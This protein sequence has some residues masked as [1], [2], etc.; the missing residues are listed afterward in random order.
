VL[1]STPLAVEI[2]PAPLFKSPRHCALAVRFIR[3]RLRTIL[4]VSRVC[5]VA[6]IS[7]AAIALFAIEHNN[8][9]AT[10]E[11]NK[12]IEAE[13]LNEALCDWERCL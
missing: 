12:R 4:D 5:L 3:I 10:F 1:E 8:S 9:N 2:F 7:D 11:R 6:D 13:A